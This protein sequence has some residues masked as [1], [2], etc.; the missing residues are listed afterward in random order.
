[1]YICISVSLPTLLSVFRYFFLE[2][3]LKRLLQW[4]ELVILLA[5]IN[6]QKKIT[7]LTIDFFATTFQTFILGN[8]L[9]NTPNV[10]YDPFIEAN[11]HPFSPL[12][13]LN[14]DTFFSPQSFTSFCMIC[15][16][17]QSISLTPPFLNLERTFTNCT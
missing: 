14:F 9:F 5:Y 8:F 2:N 4:T 16:F 1:M 3:T 12:N 7:L 13:L 17:T 15:M 11:N 10:L 6:N